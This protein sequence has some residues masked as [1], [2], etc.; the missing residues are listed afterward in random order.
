MK[1]MEEGKEGRAMERDGEVDGE[2]EKRGKEKESR[3]IWENYE[4]TM[5]EKWERWRVW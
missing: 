4:S 3:S 5:K 2:L 1:E